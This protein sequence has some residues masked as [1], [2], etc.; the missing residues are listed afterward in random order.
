MARLD[1][2]FI[3]YRTFVISGRKK[4]AFGIGWKQADPTMVLENPMS[5]S[6]FC[7]VKKQWLRVWQEEDFQVDNRQE[8]RQDKGNT[9][10][11]LRFSI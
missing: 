10:Q 3:P 2:C 7:T 4:E 1:F 11:E 8:K 6:C 5:S 9:K